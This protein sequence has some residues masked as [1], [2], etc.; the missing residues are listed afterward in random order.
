MTTVTQRALPRTLLVA[1]LAFA[2]TIASFGITTAP[3]HAQAPAKGYS[4]S[5]ASAVSAPRREVI[6]GVLWNCSGDQ[7]SGPIDGARPA[8]TCAHVVKKF[9]A[10]TR[11]ATPKGELS[12]EDLQRCN[13]AA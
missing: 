10:I 13:A 11:F 3:A 4:V 5:L 9:G 7:C 1:G 12:A 8:N 2:G 6:N